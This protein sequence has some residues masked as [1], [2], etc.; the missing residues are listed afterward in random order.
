MIADDVSVL[1]NGWDL[2]PEV[3]TTAEAQRILNENNV[4]VSTVAE[5]EK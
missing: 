4:G 3:L 1:L 5:S 2:N